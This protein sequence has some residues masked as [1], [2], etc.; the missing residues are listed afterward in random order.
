V[1]Q[2][3]AQRRT[4]VALGIVL[5]KCPCAFPLNPSLDVNQYAHK[6]W[7]SSEGFPKGAI[8]S[9]A[10]TPDGYLWLGTEFGLLRFDGVRSVPWMPPTREQ[11]PGNEIRKL[12][13]TRDGT[14]W[15]ATFGGLASWKAGRLVRY[16]ELDGQRV[17]TLLEDREG[18]VWAGGF[19]TPTGRLCA[20]RNDSV[21]CYGDDGRFGNF[22]LSLFEYKG[23]LWA[24]TETG[25]WR[26]KPDAPKLYP[27]S[28]PVPEIQDLIAGDNGSLWIA[29]RGGIRQL[30]DGR[31]QPYPLPTRGQFNPSRL[32]R[33]R[34]GGLWIGTSGQGLVHLH[35][36]RT[37]VFAA[38]DG[39]SGDYVTS[40]YEDREGNIWAATI[41][42]LDRFRDFAMPTLSVKQGLSSARIESV[43]A[44]RGGSIW[45]GSHEGLNRWNN[46]QITIYRRPGVRLPTRP[47]EGSAVREITDVGLPDDAVASLLQDERG[48]IWVST[49]RG[50]ACFEDGRITPVKS[51]PTTYVHAIAEESEG[52]IWINDQNLGLF[53]LRDGKL[54][55]QIAWAKLGRQDYA[56]ALISGRSQ[57]G[58]WLGFVQGGVAYF[59]DGKVRT[60]YEA[61]GGLG[62][63]RVNDFRLDRDGTLWVATGGG[64]SRLKDGRIA[65]LT[66]R[67]GLPCDAVQWMIEDDA[68]SVWL[69]MPCGLVRIA[70]P[71]LDAWAADPAR[72]IKGTVF[73]SFDGI[74]SRANAWG[75]TPH[76]AKSPDGKLW[77]VVD[78]GVSVIDPRQ[79]PVNKLQPPVHIA[80]VTA[81][82]KAY[83]GTSVGSGRLRLPPLVRDLEIEYT[84]LSL[85]APEKNRFR[86]KL[87]GRDR[88]WRED[89]DKLR[90]AIYTDLPPRHYRFRVIASNNSGV[91]NDVGASFDFSIAPTVYQS[92]WFRLS[93]AAA[94]LAALALLYRLRLVYLRQQFNMRLDERVGE[95]TRIAR[96][97]HDTLLQSFQGVLLKFHAVT[98]LLRDQPAE[99]GQ[100]LESAIEEA[101]RAIAEGRDAVQGLRSSTVVT[102]DL[103][104]AIT[105]FGDNLVADRNS[106]DSPAFRVQVEGAPRSIVPIVRDEVYRIAGEALRNAFG[107]AGARRIEV[108]IL[109]DKRQL[110]LRVRDD[111]KGIDP[112]VLG[113]GGREGHHGLP[114]MRERAQLVGGKLAV[115]SEVDSGTEIEL[116]I[117]AAVAYAKR[118]PKQPGEGTE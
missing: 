57:G 18:T 54:V 81:D 11:L 99:A 9:I 51:A 112:Q 10:Q 79:L 100:R 102:E 17:I 89:T 31:A 92:L 61:A 23:H 12:L 38:V 74:R 45:L 88:D 78:G 105:T 66:S 56:T 3:R 70:R 7:P 76:V 53:H 20:I 34:E 82:G 26:W 107:H 55:E 110:R 68:K 46:G 42:G 106:A 117:P 62:V 29:M 69:N 15:I 86:Y 80:K 75:N 71:E 48:R 28:G 72:T 114:G 35:Q 65:T 32:L 4:L 40:L 30:V 118:G 44:D 43:L 64:L 85:V 95:R 5:A 21:R 24:G 22:V 27:V 1:K 109:Y 113:A 97:L 39:L 49:A 101:R 41:L 67:S 83:D 33:D 94:I 8:F 84:A 93:C 90:K 96:D 116:T 91:W 36:G 60:W 2:T 115:W 103:A 87:E 58:L 108:D 77:F 50:V 14:L 25:L 59:K 73:D 47:V 6:S 37:D 98:F 16:P 13:V 111:G 52:N 19:G 63:G 104:R